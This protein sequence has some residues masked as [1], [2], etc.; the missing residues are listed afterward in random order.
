[1]VF[2]AYP[3]SRPTWSLPSRLGGCR[4]SPFFAEFIMGRGFQGKWRFRSMDISKKS[5]R[6]VTS[7]KTDAEHVRHAG[8]KRL[9][10]CNL[11]RSLFNQSV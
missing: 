7:V 4:L 10:S 5:W 11:H 6:N 8:K 9:Y 1:V 2:S 3:I